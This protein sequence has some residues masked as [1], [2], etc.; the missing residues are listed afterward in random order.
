MAIIC[1]A[2]ASTQDTRFGSSPD[3]PSDFESNHKIFAE[4]RTYFTISEQGR[5][6]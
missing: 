2:Y 3:K 4:E 6:I 5:N 1:R